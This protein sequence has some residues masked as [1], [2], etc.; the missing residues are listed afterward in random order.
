L[1]ST[2]VLSRNSKY[3]FERTLRVLFANFHK[4]SLRMLL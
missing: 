3:T 4:L 1:S 2:A